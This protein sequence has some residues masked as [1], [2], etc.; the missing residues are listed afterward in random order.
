VAELLS[1]RRNRGLGGKQSDV[2]GPAEK[3][4]RH[5]TSERRRTSA[6]ATRPATATADETRYRRNNGGSCDNVSASDG[7]GRKSPSAST[8]LREL[9]LHHDML[10]AAVSP[11]K[12]PKAKAYVEGKVD[13]FDWAESHANHDDDPGHDDDLGEESA[14]KRQLGGRRAAATGQVSGAKASAL[15]EEESEGDEEIEEAAAVTPVRTR[16][17]HNSSRKTLSR[18]RS[19][20]ESE[21]PSP[22][23]SAMAASTGDTSRTDSPI[24]PDSHTFGTSTSGDLDDPDDSSS[25]SHRRH[26]RHASQPRHPLDQTLESK[27]KPS[28][29]HVKVGTAAVV[30]S[31]L[32]QRLQK[33]DRQESEEAQVVSV[34]DVLLSVDEVQHALSPDSS[35]QGGHRHHGLTR[36]AALSPDLPPTSFDE[37]TKEFSTPVPSRAASRHASPDLP[38]TN[39]AK[40]EEQSVVSKWR[41]PQPSSARAA[42]QA[43]AAAVGGASASQSTGSPRPKLRAPAVAALLTR[44][45]LLLAQDQQQRANLPVHIPP[46]PCA[47]APSPRE[48]PDDTGKEEDETTPLA[49]STNSPPFPSTASVSGLSSRSRSGDVVNSDGRSPGSSELDQAKLVA[50]MLLE[51]AAQRESRPGHI[52]YCT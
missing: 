25:S 23:S 27:P 18:R 11:T 10:Q 30:P 8:S 46:S 34:R 20:D 52:Q 32:I 39:P 45:G 4:R 48:R 37:R 3:L 49:S 42:R 28:T 26:H 5:I 50:A 9:L 33:L 31:D 16:T 51:D 43:L 6:S 12:G 29:A 44:R 38:L 1:G 41:A 22:D 17:Q 7:S 40:K 24:T 35:D 19:S 2:E 13:T 15:F 21:C 14:R 36:R 47:H